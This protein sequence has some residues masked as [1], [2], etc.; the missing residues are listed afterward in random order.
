MFDCESAI[1]LC[2]FKRITEKWFWGLLIATVGAIFF[3]SGTSGPDQARQMLENRDTVFFII[4]FLTSIL[5]IVIGSTELPRDVSSNI[6]MIILTKPI[7][8]F[9]I[10]LGKYIG[11]ILV[12]FVFCSICSIAAVG[13]LWL[14]SLAPNS[15]T[16]KMLGL[17]I[18]RTVLIAGIVTAFA[19]NLSEIPSMIFCLIFVLICHLIPYITSLFANAPIP[20]LGK[21]AIGILLHFIPDLN[22]FSLP[23]IDISSMASADG[24]GLHIYTASSEITIPPSWGHFALACAYALMYTCIVLAGAILT[25]RRRIIA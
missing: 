23:V 18:M 10:I 11:I 2:T 17:A 4:N 25:F 22:T 24:G 14:N 21:I 19:A 15:V 5:C 13:S 20:T 12:A 7:E 9:Q 1:A 6:I 8:R 16:I 3:A